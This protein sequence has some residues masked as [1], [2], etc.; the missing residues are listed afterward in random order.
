MLDLAI[1]QIGDS[2]TRNIVTSVCDALEGVLTIV[3]PRC[4]ASTSSMYRHVNYNFS[5]SP[6]T[7]VSPYR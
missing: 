2:M 3:S 7:F 6:A 4:T 5:I 1:P